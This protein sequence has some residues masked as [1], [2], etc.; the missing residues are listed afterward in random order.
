[1]DFIFFDIDIHTPLIQAVLGSIII[2]I[3]LRPK[4]NP[5]KEAWCGLQEKIKTTFGGDIE[6]KLTNETITYKVDESDSE[7]QNNFSKTITAVAI[8]NAIYGFTL[9]FYAEL[10]DKL[11]STTTSNPIQYGLIAQGIITL[12]YVVLYIF[13]IIDKK[14]SL[15]L[16]N[17]I[18]KDKKYS[19][20]KSSIFVSI[21]EII[22]FSVSVYI[23]YINPNNACLSLLKHTEVCCNIFLLLFLISPLI[24]M[25]IKYYCIRKKVEK[26]AAKLCLMNTLCSKPYKIEDRLQSLLE[27]N[28]QKELRKSFYYKK[29]KEYIN[30]KE[31]YIID[32]L[33]KQYQQVDAESSATVEHTM[34]VEENRIESIKSTIDKS[35]LCRYQKKLLKRKIK[36]RVPFNTRGNSDTLPFLLKNGKA[37]LS[38]YCEKLYNWGILTKKTN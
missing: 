35:F 21:V 3:A 13:K 5:F 30:N 6:I 22:I 27:G 25:S 12:L 17:W 8:I 29:A 26:E 18:E 23:C 9:L 14:C 32:D 1:M 34:T 33:K 24:L 16:K 11:Q 15:L 19:Y 10:L 31:L 37:E 7:Q 4:A 2:A 36:K 20:I 28:Q 38:E